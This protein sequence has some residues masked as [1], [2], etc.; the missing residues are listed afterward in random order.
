VSPVVLVPL[1]VL[2]VAALV[3]TVMV[4]RLAHELSCLQVALAALADV[5]RDLVALRAE[6]TAAGV[7]TRLTP[8]P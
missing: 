3:S 2:A 1:L 8:N 7:S 5:P 4:R 6:T